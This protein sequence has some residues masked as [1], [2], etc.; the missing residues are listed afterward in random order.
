[1]DWRDAPDFRML[2]TFDWMNDTA[3]MRLL[4]HRARV[5]RHDDLEGAELNYKALMSPVAATVTVQ[6]LAGLAP[7]STARRDISLLVTDYWLVLATPLRLGRLT[8]VRIYERGR[9]HFHPVPHFDTDSRYVY[10]GEISTATDAHAVSIQLTH[11]TRFELEKL[12]ELLPAP[13]PTPSSGPRAPRDRRSRARQFSV[14]GAITTPPAVE[15][16][17]ALAVETENYG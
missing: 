2:R 16:E 10:R 3:E 13:L 9:S 14:T 1:M 8:R 6:L 5:G 11:S 15:T 12:A 7:R 17:R 4:R